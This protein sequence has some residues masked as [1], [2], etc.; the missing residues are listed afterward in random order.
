MYRLAITIIALTLST[1]CIAGARN[2]YRLVFFDDSSNK[3]STTLRL[4]SDYFNAAFP[5][6]I[7]R[8]ESK[9]RFI[10]IDL[11]YIRKLPDDITPKLIHDSLDHN[12]RATE[13]L[14]RA[15]RTFRDSEINQGFDGLVIF[16]NEKNFFELTTISSI[17]NGYVKTARIKDEGNG[18]T[19]AT[20]KI[21]FCESTA[22]LDYAYSGK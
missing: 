6:N 13:S 19:P 7:Y 5:A 20:L 18:L 21:L 17:S 9:N 4:F 12:G 15:L 11:V 22:E 14:R 3:S 10:D 2:G 8:C 16:R 1:S